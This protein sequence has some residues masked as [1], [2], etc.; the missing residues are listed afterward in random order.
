MGNILRRP[1]LAVQ[2]GR[3]A[4]EH[5]QALLLSAWDDMVLD[6]W[7]VQYGVR[8]RLADARD[9]FVER[10]GQTR[11]AIAGRIVQAA[12]NLRGGARRAAARWF[13]PPA[14]GPDADPPILRAR[15]AIHPRLARRRILLE[16]E[17]LQQNA[18]PLSPERKKL[19]STALVKV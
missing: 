18:R 10:V 3:L 4:I 7:F 5:G 11:D 19:W 9:A 17:N 6:L 15:P 2:A 16:L 14:R 12:R 8:R 13:G 1:Q